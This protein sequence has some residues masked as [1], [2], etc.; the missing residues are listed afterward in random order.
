MEVIQ[1]FIIIIIHN[2]TG[3]KK[4][5]VKVALYGLISFH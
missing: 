4:E 5:F 2:P 1:M 3:Y